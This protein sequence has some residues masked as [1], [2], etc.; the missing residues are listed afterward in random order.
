MYTVK[1]TRMINNYTDLL[2][3]GLD[4]MMAMHIAK[5]LAALVIL[6]IAVSDVGIHVET[7]DVSAR[8]ESTVLFSFK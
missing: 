3:T 6:T 5:K 4:K 1:Q 2:K 8:A 7:Y